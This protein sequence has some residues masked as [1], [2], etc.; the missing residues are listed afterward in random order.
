MVAQMPLWQKALASFGGGIMDDIR[1]VGQHLGMASKADVARARE[2]D[3]ALDRTSIGKVGKFVGET[4]PIAAAMLAPEAVLG[5]AGVALPTATSARMALSGLGGLAQGYLSPYATGK[6]H[7]L[8]T[9]IGGV[10]NSL[11]PGASYLFKAGLSRFAATPAA[12]ELLEKGVRLK[13]GQAL[14]GF[15]KHIEDEMTS[16]PGIG[17]AIRNARGRGLVDLNRAAIDDALSHVKAS[18][19]KAMQMGR[20][21]VL[22]ADDVISRAYN[23]TLS[24]M[25]GTLDK[26]LATEIGNVWQKYGPALGDKADQFSSLLQNEVL[27][28][29]SPAGTMSGE[30]YQQVKSELGRISTRMRASDDYHVRM[31]GNAVR[32]VQ[33]GLR[34]MLDRNNPRQLLDQLTGADKAFEKLA[35]IKRAAGYEGSADG[36]FTPGNLKRASRALDNSRN[37]ANYL[38]GKAPMQHVAEVG[39]EVLPDKVPDSGTAERN[40]YNGFKLNRPSSY[41]G[42]ALSPFYSRPGVAVMQNLLAPRNGPVR[43]FLAQLAQ[44]RGLTATAG[45]A[46]AQ[47]GMQRTQQNGP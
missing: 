2:G 3:V 1:G 34:Q 17:Y 18:L 38:A 44:N 22:H 6:E 16:S 46:A 25:T 27:N 40:A 36:I 31:L 29:F 45:V 11:A 35:R 10:V 30:V 21:A 33:H 24:K 32:D 7:H 9:E 23:D 8:N 5:T 4:A 28:K 41:I 43:N 14:G 26:K 20:D 42:L 13:P 47:A 39:Q 12:R 19:P 37:K 15:F